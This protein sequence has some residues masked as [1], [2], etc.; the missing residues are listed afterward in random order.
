MRHCRRVRGIQR[1]GGRKVYGTVLDGGIS[2][3]HSSRQTASWSWAT[4]PTGISDEVP[5]LLDSRLRIPV[6][7]RRCRV[8]ERCGGHR[9]HRFQNS[10]ADET[11]ACIFLL[12]LA[13]WAAA[14][15]DWCR[16]GEYRLAS[17]KIEVSGDGKVSPADLSPY[18][19]QQSNSYLVFG[20][21]PFLNVYNW[22]DG[23]GRESTGCGRR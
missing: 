11:K 13:L 6:V 4:N 3:R 9:G 5:R 20:W 18:L 12:V 16:K 7:R 2:I 10:D 17:N 15:P 21:N 19:R 22:S 14:P 1:F 23:S 8:V